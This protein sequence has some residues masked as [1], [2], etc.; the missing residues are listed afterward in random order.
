MQDIIAR[1]AEMNDNGKSNEHVRTK[2][3]AC[4]APGRC[5]RTHGRSRVFVQGDMYPN[6]IATALA[7]WTNSRAFRAPP[8]PPAA[9][10]HRRPTPFAACAA[11]F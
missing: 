1:H 5:S 6:T 8:P 2:A 10:D 9:L 3:A 7:L 11:R 4:S